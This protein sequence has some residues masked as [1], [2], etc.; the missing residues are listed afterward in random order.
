VVRDRDE[1]RVPLLL[2]T[3]PSPK[4]FKRAIRGV[5]QRMAAFVTAFRALQLQHSVLTVAASPPQ[6]S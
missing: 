4:E 3:M 2:E 1:L 5:S 6:R